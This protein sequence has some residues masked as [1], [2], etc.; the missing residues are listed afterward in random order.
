MDLALY[1]TVVKYSISG[2]KPVLFSTSNPLKTCKNYPGFS[3]ASLK[4]FC[5]VHQFF[6]LV[7]QVED[8]WMGSGCVGDPGVM[9]IPRVLLQD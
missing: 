1:P 3:F 7:T 9:K 6:G 2:E 4:L 5:T 8:L